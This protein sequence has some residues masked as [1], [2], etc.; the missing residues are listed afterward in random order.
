[1]W[2]LGHWVVGGFAIW[3]GAK[4]ILGSMGIV[5]GPIVLCWSQTGLGLTP[6]SASVTS[7]GLWVLTPHLIE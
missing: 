2:G 5:K 7:S 3:S 4:V 1:M 6:A